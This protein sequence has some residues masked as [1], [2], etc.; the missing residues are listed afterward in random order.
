MKIKEMTR[1]TGLKL[2]A[3]VVIGGVIMFSFTACG[4]NQET[5]PTMST[6]VET[7]TETETEEP[8]VVSGGLYNENSEL[9]TGNTETAITE[10]YTIKFKASS[11]DDILAEEGKTVVIPE[12]QRQH[13]KDMMATTFDTF[14]PEDTDNYT[15]LE[16]TENEDGSKTYLISIAS[17]DITNGCTTQYSVDENG[18]AKA[19]FV[20]KPLDYADRLASDFG[21]NFELSVDKEGNVSLEK[22]FDLFGNDVSDITLYRGDCIGWSLTKG[23]IEVDFEFLDELQLSQDLTL[24]PV[25]E[26]TY[27]QDKEMDTSD[28]YWV[29]GEANIPVK[30]GKSFEKNDLNF[31]IIDGKLVSIDG[32]K[33]I[34]LK[35]GVVTDAPKKEETTKKST[36]DNNGQANNGEQTSTQGGTGD[37]QTGGETQANTNIPD[38]TPATS[39]DD[40]CNQFGLESPIDSNTKNPES[41]GGSN[42]A[43]QW[44]N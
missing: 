36:T 37:S 13:V 16:E 22:I 28:G 32:K 33:V 41:T 43:I 30:L 18:K 31:D 8:G 24:Y 15:V 9:G 40:F 2:A 34:D 29:L 25:M 26:N 35:T 27:D 39:W 1:K 3:I 23:A 20:Y 19:I 44:G 42:G 5:T 11:N 17:E 10:E 12:Y 4:K 7:V 21:I 6:Q 38:E 14:D